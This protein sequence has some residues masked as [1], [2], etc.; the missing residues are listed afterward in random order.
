MVDDVIPSIKQIVKQATG[1]PCATK[2]RAPH[3]M[4]KVCDDL[5]VMPV[6]PILRTSCVVSAAN[7]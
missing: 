3:E 5:H 1:G 4:K 7:L 6:P 2:Q